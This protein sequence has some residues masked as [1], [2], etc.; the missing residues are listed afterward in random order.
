MGI[1]RLDFITEAVYTLCSQLNDSSTINMIGYT[2]EI[3]LKGLP[4]VALYEILLSSD[5]YMG[6]SRELLL[7]DQ[8]NL[9]IM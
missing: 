1:K 5:I 2:S 3:A 4:M 9:L 7:S 6:I 8:W